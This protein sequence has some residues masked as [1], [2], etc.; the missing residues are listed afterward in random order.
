MAAISPLSLPVIR[1]KKRCPYN[2]LHDL[3]GAV[4]VD[5]TLVDT[6]LVT[7]PSLGTLTTGGFAGGD[8]ESLGGDA[9]GALDLKLLVLGAGDQVVAN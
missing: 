3:R 9:H 4:Q 8:A 6:H 5:D 2:L 7:I 1:W